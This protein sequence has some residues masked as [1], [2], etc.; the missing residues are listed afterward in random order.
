MTRKEWWIPYAFLLPA[1]LGLAVFR[2]VPTAY[3]AGRSLFRT[4][5]GLDPRTIF[6]G[7]DNY[8][9]LLSD[10]VFWRSAKVT[11]VYSIIVNPFQT[12][13]A[14]LLAL[15]AN[16]RVRGIGIFRAIFF[17]PI[18]VS[19]LVACIIWRM[20]L[21]PQSG[22]LNGISM[23]VGLPAQP[24]LTSPNQALFSIILVV[25]WIGVGY[26]MVFILAGL[27]G[28]PS[29]IYESAAID[30]ASG[31]RTFFQITLPLLGRIIGFVVIADTISNF[32]MFV[33]VFQ[34]TAGGPQGS[35]NLLMYE[36]YRSQFIGLDVGRASSIT[37]ILLL[38]LLAVVGLQLA[39]LRRAER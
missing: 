17:V 10:P 25:S 16:S 8:R 13:L 7:Y 12:V 23:W 35:T 6:V 3:A 5:F 20:M 1:L 28:I 37:M 24:F 14:V 15:I 29:T 33:A 4:S 27:Q 11:L 32:L 19:R 26:W 21:D 39:A 30:G 2:L 9:A 22:L 18:A 38:L 36:A 31:L 34:L